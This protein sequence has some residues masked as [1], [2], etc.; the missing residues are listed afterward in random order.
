MERVEGKAV[1]AG[2]SSGLS[3][4]LWVTVG[5]FA[6]LSTSALVGILAASVVL[7]VAVA[8]GLQMRAR[9]VLRRAD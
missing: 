7:P 8:K 5:G 2:I 3:A 6:V 4:V 1:V 9:R